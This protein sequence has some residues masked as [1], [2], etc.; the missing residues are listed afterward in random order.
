MGWAHCGTD[1]TGREIGYVIAATC[2]HPGCKAKIDRGLGYACGGMHGDSIGCEKY[3]CGEH[4]R[5]D[6]DPGEQRYTQ[7]CDECHLNNI[8]QRCED[9]QSAIEGA[10][11]SIQHL[12]SPEAVDAK[13]QLAEALMQWDEI[14]DIP[15]DL[16][17]NPEQRQRAGIMRQRTA[18]PLEA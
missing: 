16:I 6:Y 1:S 2:D 12:T 17:T 14:S 13:E 7:F 10:L 18:P 9:F 11:E 5:Y 15:L 3:F 4:M 8:E